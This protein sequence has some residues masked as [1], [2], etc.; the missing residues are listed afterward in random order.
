MINHP[1]HGPVS[2]DVD[3]QPLQGTASAGW[4]SEGSLHYMS[5]TPAEI[6]AGLL[7]SGQLEI[8]S[9]G[10]VLAVP[11]TDPNA[12]YFGPMKI[13]TGNWKIEVTNPQST[14]GPGENLDRYV[15]WVCMDD[16]INKVIFEY[17]YDNDYWFYRHW[18][19]GT[20]STV[21]QEPFAVEPYA[22]VTDHAAVANNTTMNFTLDVP[23]HL[24][25]RFFHWPG[26][27][28]PGTGDDHRTY[29][30]GTVYSMPVNGAP[31]HN[32]TKVFSIYRN[33]MG[34]VAAM[35]VAISYLG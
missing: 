21:D 28:I 23:A 12:F 1:H 13:A 24:Y 35:T 22:I 19:N 34:E 4:L 30:H 16:L 26:S 5:Y 27:L 14:P 11:F 3:V 29:Y 6:A 25:L 2:S 17:N 20:H 15:M 31:V 32:E 8:T 18:P 7:D 9:P 33:N 10:S